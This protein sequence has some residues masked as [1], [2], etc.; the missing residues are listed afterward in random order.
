MPMG[1]DASNAMY[2]AY[3]LTASRSIPEKTQNTLEVSASQHKE[4]TASLP[5]CL[6]LA[7]KYFDHCRSRL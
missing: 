4:A 5:A 3:I 6:A 1:W 2:L 7:G